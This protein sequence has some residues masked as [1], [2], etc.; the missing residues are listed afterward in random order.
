MEPKKEAVA[1]S[2]PA[3]CIKQYRQA[4]PKAAKIAIILNARNGGSDMAPNPIPAIAAK[5][6]SEIISKIIITSY[7]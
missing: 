7:L 2:N 4:C 5:K 3:K 6:P 1:M